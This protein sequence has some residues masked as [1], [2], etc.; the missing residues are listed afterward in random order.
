MQNTSTTFELLLQ[1]FFHKFLRLDT[2]KA[3]RKRFGN[4]AGTVM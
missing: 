4:Y 2:K 1:Q 3:T